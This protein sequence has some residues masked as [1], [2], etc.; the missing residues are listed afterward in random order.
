MDKCCE[1]YYAPS[2]NIARIIILVMQ[3]R[4]LLSTVEQLIRA[5]R[6]VSFREAVTRKR[7]ARSR[8]DAGFKVTVQS[9]SFL[10]IA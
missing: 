10:P 4:P 8:Y 6:S 2:T 3:W 1:E 7:L 5:C 9:K